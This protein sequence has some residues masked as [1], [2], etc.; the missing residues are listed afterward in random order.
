MMQVLD[1]I[2][3]HCLEVQAHSWPW[4]SLGWVRTYC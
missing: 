3:L 4:V 1:L 2:V